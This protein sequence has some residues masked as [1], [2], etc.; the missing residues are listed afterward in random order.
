MRSLGCGWMDFKAEVWVDSEPVILFVALCSV[1]KLI[2]E[3]VVELAMAERTP[4][5]Q[6]CRCE[7]HT[8][9]KNLGGKGGERP[10][11]E[12]EDLGETWFYMENSLE[13][14]RALTRLEGELNSTLLFDHGGRKPAIS[15]GGL[16]PPWMF[17]LGE[18][19]LGPDGGS[20]HKALLDGRHAQ[21]GEAPRPSRPGRAS[22]AGNSCND[23]FREVEGRGD[24]AGQ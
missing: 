17:F 7:G 12:G 11:T 8:H 18:V 22:I 15:V 13:E 3:E 23:N 5:V 4:H 2:V 9:G 19:F 21:F 16:Y 1:W 14:A 10:C 20:F 24:G 6:D